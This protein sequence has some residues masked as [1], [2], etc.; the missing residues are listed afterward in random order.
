MFNST[1]W[2][3]FA[4]IGST[5]PWWS[6]V[7]SCTSSSPWQRPVLSAF[8]S[9]HLTS[10]STSTRTKWCKCIAG[11]PAKNEFPKTPLDGSPFRGDQ[12]I[13]SKSGP[14]TLSGW[15][16]VTSTDFSFI[17]QFVRK[18][19]K[20]RTCWCQSGI[21]KSEFDWLIRR[22]SRADAFVNNWRVASRFC[23]VAAQLHKL[24]VWYNAPS[25]A[26]MLMNRLINMSNLPSKN[27]PRYWISRPTPPRP[28]TWL[29]A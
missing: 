18:R 3:R 19:R 9:T 6:I 29:V 16:H 13:V 12:H 10:S 2:R 20:R 27:W 5:L 25:I 17:L 24:Q 1:W 22:Q 23:S 8:S 15:N 14:C 26:T 7:C 21:D 11:R 4:R 28:V